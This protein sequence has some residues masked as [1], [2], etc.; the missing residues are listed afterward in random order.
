MLNLES[1][2]CDSMSMTHF[3]FIS[4]CRS[5]L[6][7]LIC[8]MMVV[9]FAVSSA[10]VSAVHRRVRW[11]EL[12]DDVSKLQLWNDI[13]NTETSD[14]RATTTQGSKYFDCLVKYSCSASS[15]TKVLKGVEIMV[16]SPVI[17]LLPLFPTCSTEFYPRTNAPCLHSQQC[18]K[19]LLFMFYC[20]FVF[21]DQA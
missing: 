19:V 18:E 5:S 16:F 10:S 1:I 21:E 11:L 14:C 13:E 6:W 4:P 3:L 15:G 2:C 17:V 7:D 20:L 9:H 12:T 8:F